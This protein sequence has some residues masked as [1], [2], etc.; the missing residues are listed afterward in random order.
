MELGRSRGGGALREAIMRVVSTFILTATF[1]G[2]TISDG[3]CPQ[4]SNLGAP[5]PY[6]TPAVATGPD[7]LRKVSPGSPGQAGVGLRAQSFTSKNAVGGGGT[8]SSSAGK[9][10]QI[11]PVAAP[12]TYA[13]PSR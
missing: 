12:Q 10:Y 9:I 13:R 5:V 1:L 8:A 6:S 7:R 2:L 3:W 11:K 4:P